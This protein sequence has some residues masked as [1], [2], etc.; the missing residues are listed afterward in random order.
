M[1]F[2][3]EQVTKFL[4]EENPSVA[5]LK[6]YPKDVILSA[7]L[8]I[9]ENNKTYELSVLQGNQ[10]ML[11]KQI[12]LE[13]IKLDREKLQAA[14]EVSDGI[15]TKMTELKDVQYGPSS[16]ARVAE[17]TAKIY[18]DSFSN[19]GSSSGSGQ[20]HDDDLAER[21]EIAKKQGMRWNSSNIEPTR[22]S[23][24]LRKVEIWERAYGRGKDTDIDS[25]IS[26]E[27]EDLLRGG[28]S[29]A[30]VVGIC[31]SMEQYLGIGPSSQYLRTRFKRDVEKYAKVKGLSFKPV[32]E[33][34]PA[35]DNDTLY[36][37]LIDRFMGPGIDSNKREHCLKIINRYVGWANGK[38]NE[39]DIDMFRKMVS[40]HKPVGLVYNTANGVEPSVP[41]V[42][43]AVV[44][45]K[46]YDDQLKAFWDKFCEEKGLV[47]V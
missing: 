40:G 21:V 38:W 15:F 42:F 32:E 33:A 5:T 20:T 18:K 25:I 3:I 9:L 14:K 22:R 47:K 35:I 23:T 4:Q 24:V 17:A 6:K 10:S 31:E 27:Y 11:D 16:I 26:L 8:K 28:E 44:V 7:Y 37:E 30:Y 43:Q 19:G 39:V 29:E 45:K 13:R 1:I 46:L 41:E 12:E 34:E 36:N 2:N